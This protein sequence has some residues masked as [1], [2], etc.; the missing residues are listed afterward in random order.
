MVKPCKLC[1]L[2][3]E[4]FGCKHRCIKPPSEKSQPYQ[5][6]APATA[7][8]A[9]RL[10][11]RPADARSTGILADPKPARACRAGEVLAAI[12]RLTAAFEKLQATLTSQDK[13]R[14]DA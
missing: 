3:E 12:D 5:Q 9:G 2:D 10:A 8:S 7:Q 11:P 14:M 6:K 1:G 4:K 13:P